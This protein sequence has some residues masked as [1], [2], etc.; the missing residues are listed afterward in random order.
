MQNC[1]FRSDTWRFFSEGPNLN[2]FFPKFYWR[3]ATLLHFQSDF[4]NERKVTCLCV[5]DVGES[6]SEVD[7]L[8]FISN[9]KIVEF[10]F[11]CFFF[12]SFLN[13]GGNKMSHQCGTRPQTFC[14]KSNVIKSSPTVWRQQIT[15]KLGIPTIHRPRQPRDRAAVVQRLFCCVLQMLG[16]IMKELPWGL[17]TRI[18]SNQIVPFCRASAQ[19]KLQAFIS[20]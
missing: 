6:F 20:Q 17:I 2:L 11:M 15:M 5:F 9:P 12:L 13:F 1:P 8:I 10:P 7:F 19:V 14:A 16:D 3:P 4:K 18:F